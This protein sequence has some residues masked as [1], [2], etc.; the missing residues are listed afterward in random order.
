MKFNG[1]VLIFLTQT[2][3]SVAFILLVLNLDSPKGQGQARDTY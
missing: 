1:E 2:N 3:L